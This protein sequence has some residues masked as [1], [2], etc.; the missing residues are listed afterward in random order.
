[1]ARARN[2]ATAR[3]SLTLFGGQFTFREANAIDSQRE[4]IAPFI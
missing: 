3:P 4:P 2:T 1:M